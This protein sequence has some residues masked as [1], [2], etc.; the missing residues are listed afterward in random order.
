MRIPNPVWLSPALSALA[1][2][3]P[4][5]DKPEGAAVSPELRQELRRMIREEVRAALTDTV[6]E[7]VG[8]WRTQAG[9]T[10]V[11]ALP[12][13]KATPLALP[14]PKVIFHKGDDPS[15][16][17]FDVIIEHGDDAAKE[18]GK[19][20]V[21]VERA[22]PKK[23]VVKKGVKSQG[24]AEAADKGE[25]KA[26]RLRTFTTTGD[27]DRK[28]MVIRKVQGEGDDELLEVDG[29]M[30]VVGP[31]GAQ[32][33]LRWIDEDGEG[34]SVIT[35]LPSGAEVGNDGDKAECEGCDG[36]SGGD[37]AAPRRTL[38]LRRIHL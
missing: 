2:A 34:A 35:L 23:V 20:R 33:L 28:V 12:R 25:V 14:A 16:Q 18:P 4:A 30:T 10:A 32:Q 38:Q 31:D 9:P 13:V 6:R 17:F 21:L 19:A 15:H 36:S 29:G 27:G 7:H 24:K 26:K 11:M 37:A 22:E 5:Q 8:A 3:L 1:A